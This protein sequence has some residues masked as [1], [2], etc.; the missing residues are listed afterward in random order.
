MSSTADK[1][2]AILEDFPE[3]TFTQTA[4]CQEK[5]AHRLRRDKQGMEISCNRLIEI[6]GE[7]INAKGTS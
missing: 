6:S 3:V 7:W 4:Y 5:Y 2:P 1:C